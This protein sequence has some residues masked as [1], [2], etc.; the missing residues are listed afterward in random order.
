MTYSLQ[1][2]VLESARRGGDAVLDCGSDISSRVHT[3]AGNPRTAARWIPR[4][5]GAAGQI[6]RYGDGPYSIGGH[7]GSWRRLD[8]YNSAHHKM[9][10]APEFLRRWNLWRAGSPEPQ[11]H[12]V[13]AAED[14]GID[15]VEGSSWVGTGEIAPGDRISVDGGPP[16]A[17]TEGID[18]GVRGL[19]ELV[20]REVGPT[21]SA[22]AGHSH[23][24][25]DSRRRLLRLLCSDEA[26]ANEVAAELVS[27]AAAA[28]TPAV[29]LLVQRGD[30]LSKSDGQR[31]PMLLVAFDR[32]EGV[33]D[34]RYFAELGPMT[35]EFAARLET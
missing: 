31:Y 29:Q 8:A 21:V 7:S 2:T 23:P 26:H 13:H 25:S 28:S 11:L 17:W 20:N 34:D 27:A 16:G 12:A 32:R 5:E 19:V 3:L 33:S 22:C 15:S 10:D 4:I 30:V 9:E 1:K 14:G 6:Y 35:A 24:D 18:E